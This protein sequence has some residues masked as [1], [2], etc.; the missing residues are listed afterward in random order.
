MNIVDA[1]PE[2]LPELTALLTHYVST[3]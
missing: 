1:K 2:H 3:N